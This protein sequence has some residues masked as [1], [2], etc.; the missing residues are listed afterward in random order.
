M[1]VIAKPLGIFLGFIYNLVGSYGL[2]IVIFTVIV[3]C[4]LYPL[5]ATQIK[6][7]MMMASVQPKMQEIQR[8]Y[9]N[10]Q[11]M[12][13]QKMMELYKEE[14]YNP[15]SGCLPLIIQLPIIYALFELLR[16]PLLYLGD[17]D[18][19]ILAV[20]EAFLWIQDLSQPDL[21]ILPIAAGV[22]T[23]FS[24]TMTQQQTAAAPQANGMDMNGM[25]KAMKYV[26]PIMIIFMGRSFPAGLTV[27]WFLNTAI[28]ILFNIRFNSMRR[29]VAAGIP[30]NAKKVK[31]AKDK[32]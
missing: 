10:D 31:K 7:T 29:K 3:K 23:Y 19:M 32:E 4:C 22:S 25:M 24:F 9:A 1:G 18:A 6:S 27:Y 21:W 5:Y 12:Q 30:L 8:K 16:N 20:H 11:Q 17:S 26:F 2:A 28:Q 13:Q 15:M 14:G